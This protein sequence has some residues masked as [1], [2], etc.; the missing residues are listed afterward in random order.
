MAEEN[1]KSSKQDA[2]NVSE[3]FKKVLNQAYEENKDAMDLLKS[4]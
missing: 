3:E 1:E 4:L 2:L